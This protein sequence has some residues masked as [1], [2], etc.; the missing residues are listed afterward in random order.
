MPP[1]T[2]NAFA[3]LID[4]SESDAEP[5]QQAQEIVETVEAPVK[6]GSRTGVLEKSVV[7]PGSSGVMMKPARTSWADESDSES[8]PSKV[9]APTRAEKGRAK[10]PAV[11]GKNKFAVLMGEDDAEV[12]D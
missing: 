10:K 5:E 11:A 6:I 2:K 9:E 3:A 12:S 1:A 4:D 7:S 8:S